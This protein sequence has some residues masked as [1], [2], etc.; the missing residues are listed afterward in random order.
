MTQRSCLD[1]EWHRRISI[2]SGRPLCEPVHPD[3]EHPSDDWCPS[4]RAWGP[5]GCAAG[6]LRRGG[7]AMKKIMLALLA[8]VLLI[9]CVDVRQYS[10]GDDQAVQE[11][12]GPTGPEPIAHGE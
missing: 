6:H 1:C 11:T 5:E 3:A 2:V 8:V 12:E 4:F 10:A 9:G 7:N